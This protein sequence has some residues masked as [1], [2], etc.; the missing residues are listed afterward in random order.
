M[1]AK[2]HK[3]FLF[4]L[5]AAEPSQVRLLLKHLS[6]GQYKALREIAVNLFRASLTLTS[7]QIDQLRKYGSFYRRLAQPR[8]VK[9]LREPIVLL[10]KVAKVTLDQL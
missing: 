9:L 1:F 3:P 4:F 7:D 2:S 6:P 10:V 5:L 8:K